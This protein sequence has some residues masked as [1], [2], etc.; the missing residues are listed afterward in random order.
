MNEHI[1]SFFHSSSN[2]SSEGHFHRVLPLHDGPDVSWNEIHPMVPT[3]PRGW[4]ELAQLPESDR[5]EFV[6]DFWLSTLPFQPRFTDFIGNFFRSLDGIGV[7]VTQQTFADP[8]E[9]HLVYSLSGDSGFFRGSPPITSKEEESLT[10]LFSH[11]T[12]PEDYLAFLRVHNGFF[13]YTD[14]GII[15]SS[16]LPSSVQRFRQILTAAGTLLG[17]K[18]KPVDPFTL[19]PFYE[20]FGFPC[21]QCFWEDWYP[22]QEMG[23]VY[24]CGLTHTLSDYKG[25]EA[26][27]EHMAFPT[28]LEWLM[29]YM[30]IIDF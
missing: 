17:P 15:P 23:N 22:D 9:A 30:E 16:D 27:P 28:F 24:Y 3:L 2:E 25:V 10:K 26:S 4:F 5:I 7:Y 21:Y 29:F 20:S 6:C 8:Y 18:G 1:R 14:T 13:K 19:V 12:L 11:V